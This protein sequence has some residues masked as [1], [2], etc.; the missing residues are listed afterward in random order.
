MCVRVRGGVSGCMCTCVLVCVFAY[1]WMGVFVRVWDCVLPPV[2][3]CG[4]VWGL[5]VCVASEGV[6]GCASVSPMC[7]GT[8]GNM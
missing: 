5:H 2:Y 8:S 6:Y 1:V 4:C 3:V 7:T